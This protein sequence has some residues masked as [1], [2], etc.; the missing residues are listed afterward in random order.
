MANKAKQT[1]NENPIE[2]AERILAELQAKQD[3]TVKAR[4]ADDRE[5]G[6]VSYAALAAGDKDAAEK[7]EHV[8][9]RALRRDLEIKAIQSAIA[10]AQQN[11]VEAKADEAAADQRRVALEIQRLA[12]ELREAGKLADEGLAMF[13]DATNVMQ[14]IVSRFSTL[15]LGNPSAIQF[16]S[17]GERATRTVLMETA[18]KRAFEVLPPGQRQSFASFTAEWAVMLDKVTSAKLEQTKQTEDAA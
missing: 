7:L 3:K 14:H 18:F 2:A 1:A 17:L 5:L 16:V 13:L 12:K 8:K 15:G 4:E 10:Q 9:E 11:L 6:S